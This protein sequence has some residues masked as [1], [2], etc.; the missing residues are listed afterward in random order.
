MDSRII[1]WLVLMAA[2]TALSQV[3]SVAT[4]ASAPA[5]GVTGFERLFG[6]DVRRLR[7]GGSPEEKARLAERVF[8]EARGRADDQAFV[9]RALEEVVRLASASPAHQDLLYAALRTQKVSRLKPEAECLEAMMAAGPKALA[10]MEAPAAELWLAEVWLP[11]AMAW[12][13]RLCDGGQYAKAAAVLAA[14]RDAARG[15]R[16]TMPAGLEANIQSLERLQQAASAGSGLYPAIAVLAQGQGPAAAA[17]VLGGES[18]TGR[19]RQALEMAA[20]NKDRAEVVSALDA[21]LADLHLPSLAERL[22][23]RSFAKA[24]T[25]T[26]GRI[27]EETFF[28][29][30]VVG[31]G[32]V[33]F[34]IDFSGSMEPRLHYAKEELK[35]A[36]GALPA[37]QHFQVIFFDTG[38][39]IMPPGSLVQATAA[40]KA[41]ADAFID[42]MGSGGGTN[43]SDA[44][45]GAFGLGADTIVLLTD[46]QFDNS[47]IALVDGLNATRSTRVHTIGFFSLGSQD[48]LRQVAARNGGTYKFVGDTASSSP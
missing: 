46:G 36:V 33:V 47:I 22:L 25:E 45:R 21:A 32:R 14:V 9:V 42:Q 6:K 30:P 7:E 35:R 16:L 18:A 5:A 1:R 26:L 34:V 23:M 4:V 3:A 37:S 11:D 29:V 43:P 41:Q 31:A 40:N 2:L 48:I 27:V 44:L 38:A 12:A 20:S 19:L 28:G 13:E 10:A 17:A 8:L 15:K 39:H 24:G